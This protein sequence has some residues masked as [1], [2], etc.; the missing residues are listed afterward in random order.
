MVK[1]KELL[2]QYKIF[3]EKFLP[4]V[5]VVTTASH[6]WI[7]ANLSQLLQVHNKHNRGLF[8]EN[9]VSA[10]DLIQFNSLF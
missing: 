10:N 2:T 1:K 6:H 3:L 9:I 4:V 8:V 5:T 7:Q